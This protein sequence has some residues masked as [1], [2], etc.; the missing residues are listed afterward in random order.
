MKFEIITENLWDDS[1]GSLRLGSAQ[2]WFSLYKNR[3]SYYIYENNNMY[4]P[5]NFY[6]NNHLQQEQQAKLLFLFTNRF[7]YV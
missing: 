7:V 1:Q 2:N 4:I 3:Y 5:T 6:N